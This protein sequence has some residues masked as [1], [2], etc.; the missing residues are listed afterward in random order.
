MQYHHVFFHSLIYDAKKCFEKSK[1]TKHNFELWMITIEEYKKILDSL[2]NRGYVLVNMKDLLNEKVKLPETKIPLVISFDD[3]NYYDYMFDMGMPG[4]LVL[5]GNKIVNEYINN[6]GEKEILDNIEH[7]SILENFIEE[8][9]DFSYNNARPILAITGYEGILGYRDIE[10]D[11]NELVKLIQKLK[12]KG[13]EFACHSYSH[14]ENI[15]KT[16]T[17]DVRACV[18][19]TKKWKDQIEPLVGKTDI[20]ISPF[21]IHLQ[22][23]PDFNKE[24]KK[25]GFKY[26]CGVE[27]TRKYF[28]KDNYFYFPR[29]NIDGFIFLYRNYE[30]EYY[31]GKLDYIYDKKRTKQY[32]LYGCDNLSLTLHAINCMQLP[33]I[34]L[35]GGIGEIITK[36]VINNL[37]KAYPTVYDEKY[38]HKLEKCIGK[39]IRGFDCSGLIKNYIMGGLINYEYDANLDMN[40]EMLLKASSKSGT[41]DSL[42]EIRGV[43]LYMRGHVGIYIGK[44]EVIESTSNP[45]FGDGVVKTKL[46]DRQWTHWF[47]CPTIKYKQKEV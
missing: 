27:N 45:K 14:K 25:L 4:K 17:L 19:D 43:C 32:K 21:G 18:D 11:K 1:G 38:C 7:I 15:F 24:L 3:V 46:S 6:K 23:Y 29:V 26:F 39:N 41:I 42:P 34:Y 31:Y 33:T 20:Y 40:S 30:F 8:H 47:Y 10:K 9:P 13:Y 36:D 35:W 37:K 5:N 44:G 2:Y 22:K 16:E 28:K 12:E